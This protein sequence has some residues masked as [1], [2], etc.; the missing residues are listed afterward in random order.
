MNRS[1]SP[2]AS[3]GLSPVFIASSGRGGST[4]VLDM[5]ADAN[6]MRTVF[7]PLE[8]E[9]VKG[10]APYSFAYVRECENRVDL[11]RFLQDTIYG[12]HGRLWTR[13]RID[14]RN[15]WL[16]KSN[17]NSAKHLKFQ[18]AKHIQIGRRLVRYRHQN[19]DAKPMVKFIRA[20]LMI[21]WLHKT[22]NAPVLLLLRHPGAV[23]ESKLRL[24]E[25]GWRF[26]TTLKNF[27]SN[28]ALREDY[29]NDLDIPHLS[30]MSR[31]EGFATMWCIENMVALDHAN[32]HGLCVTFYEK[33]LDDA[34]EWDRV[35]SELGLQHSP[36]DACLKKPSQQASVEKGQTEYYTGL[37]NK[38]MS[39]LNKKEIREIDR[40][41]HRFGVGFYSM[42][43]PE[44]KAVQF[45]HPTTF[46]LP[47]RPYF[48]KQPC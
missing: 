32:R 17:F 27:F 44:P 40:L 47:H 34:R 35:T 45:L 29:L 2:S 9:K 5:L 18:F 13:Y 33:L 3:S 25:G 43:D 20:N 16:G 41:L 46:R 48:H 31:A 26:E 37:K 24:W 4:W 6:N 28:R 42:N 11:K 23:V 7:E 36:V 8:P 38:W 19:P 22:F 39:R 21:G 14:R 15:L 1:K 10:A 30:T 12:N